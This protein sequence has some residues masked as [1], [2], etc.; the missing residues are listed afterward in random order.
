MSAASW[1]LTQLDQLAADLGKGTGKTVTEARAAIEASAMVVKKATQKRWAGLKHAPSL[2]AAVT[3]DMHGLAAE[4][5]PDKA[6][7]QGALGNILEFGTSKNGPTP[8]LG[9]ALTEAGPGFVA[10]MEKIA[11]KG[12][13]L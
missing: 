11:V 10:A 3:Y 6:R 5:G 9:P 13:G 1:D 8:A 7:R 2:A 12:I 4:I